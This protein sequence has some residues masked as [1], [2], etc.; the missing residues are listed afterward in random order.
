M[1]AFR[2]ILFVFFASIL[3]YTA[4]VGINHGF[5]LFEI[6]FSDMASMNWPGQFNLDF[7]TF[8]LL[9][10]LWV[11]WRHHFSPAGIAMGVLV[12]IGGML[13]LSSYLFVA[14]FQAQGDIHELLLGK[15]RARR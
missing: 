3:G 11:A 13:F 4:V 10:G 15:A 6:F 2:V 5:G 12:P 7:S 14:S 1:S 9:G 8:L